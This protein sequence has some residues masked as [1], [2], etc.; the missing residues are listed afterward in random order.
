MNG[1]I[2]AV[3]DL[4]GIMSPQLGGDALSVIVRF[5]YRIF[6]R[7]SRHNLYD[8]NKERTVRVTGG[9][10]EGA[11]AATED[12]RQATREGAGSPLYRVNRDR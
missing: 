12:G 6:T 11:D 10:S 8:K 9:E 4:T 2:T 3:S 5:C 1:V 7:F